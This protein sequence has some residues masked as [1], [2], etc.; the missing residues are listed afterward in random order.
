[1]HRSYGH[2]TITILYAQ[3]D[4]MSEVKRAKI[5]CVIQITLNHLVQQ[6]IHIII[7]LPTKHI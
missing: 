5:S 4:I 2:D 1:M 3:H 6:H 7:N